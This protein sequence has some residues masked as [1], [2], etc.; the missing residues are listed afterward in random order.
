MRDGGPADIA[1]DLGHQPDRFFRGGPTV[2]DRQV[3]QR[4]EAAVT[5]GYGTSPFAR[6]FR[7]ITHVHSLSCSR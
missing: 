3:L 4:L 2:V 1:H 7:F 5:V 6:Y